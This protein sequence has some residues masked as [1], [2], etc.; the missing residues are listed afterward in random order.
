V[1]PNDLLADFTKRMA[2]LYEDL[3]SFVLALVG[4]HLVDDFLNDERQIGLLE[5]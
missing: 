1:T 3:M 4:V 2:A 5:R